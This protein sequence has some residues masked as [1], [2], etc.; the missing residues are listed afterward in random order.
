MAPILLQL[1]IFLFRAAVCSYLA[2]HQLSLVRVKVMLMTVVR[3][4][5]SGYSS[6]KRQLCCNA[7]A[8]LGNS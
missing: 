4:W 6:M 8:G 2:H 5:N 1:L 7:M 3:D